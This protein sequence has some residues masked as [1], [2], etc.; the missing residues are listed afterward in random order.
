MTIEQKT[1]AQAGPGQAIY[2]EA[3]AHPGVAA[4]Q[5]FLERLAER[6]LERDGLLTFFA[7]N[8]Q[9]GWV[10]RPRISH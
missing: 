4:L 6:E 9:S 1:A 5:T 7:K 3:A 2:R 10:I 8:S